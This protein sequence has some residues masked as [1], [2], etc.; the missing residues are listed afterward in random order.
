MSAYLMTDYETCLMAQFA[1][2]A[3]YATDAR[4]AASLLRSAN[5]QALLSRY[6][7]KPVKLSQVT[8]N[9]VVAKSAIEQGVTAAGVR[10]E[11]LTAIYLNRIANT[12]AYQCSEGAFLNRPGYKLIVR[13]S[14]YT[15]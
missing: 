4:R 8:K 11:V 13:L 2:H 14:T 9:L 6:N 15:V 1:V 10:S 12:F 7:D 3:G 5:N